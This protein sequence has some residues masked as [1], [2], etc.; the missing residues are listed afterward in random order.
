MKAPAV[1][2]WTSRLSEW[3]R[4]PSGVSRLCVSGTTDAARALYLTALL[5]ERRRAGVE[6]RVLF[7]A[8][9]SQA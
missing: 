8:V 3:T 7:D 5:R 9:G 1:P 6:V 4:F 2:S